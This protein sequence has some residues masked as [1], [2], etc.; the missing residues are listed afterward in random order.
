M[1]NSHLL[2]VLGLIV[3]G[4]LSRLV[5]HPPNFN[6]VN[7]I[8]LFS[9][10]YFE[11]RSLSFVTAISTLFLS[12]MILGFHCTMP[13]VYLS[14]IV[15]LLIAQGLKRRASSYS[16]LLLSLACSLLFFFISNFGVWMADV[17]YPKTVHGLG[18]CFLAAIPFLTNQIFGDLIYAGVLF[19]SFALWKKTIFHEARQLKIF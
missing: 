6:A 3:I 19:G 7:A 14:F 18:L 4:I 11:S 15:I 9:A 12:D 1:N 5:P 17:L 13:F 2:T 10:F 16:I 8:V